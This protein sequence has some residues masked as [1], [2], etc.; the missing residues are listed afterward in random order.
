VIRSVLLKGLL[1]N[2][3]KNLHPA[4]S[5]VEKHIA[6][7]EELL[8][9]KTYPLPALAIKYVLSFPE[10]SA[11]LVG[12]DSL[13]YLYQSLEAANGQYLDNTDMKLA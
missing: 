1:S 12:I 8:K 7:Y 2:R 10:V 3:G 4:L 9:G 6:R 5:D 11:A 13:A